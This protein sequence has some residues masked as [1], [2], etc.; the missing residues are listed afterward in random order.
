MSGEVGVSEDMD[1][2]SGDMCID[3]GDRETVGG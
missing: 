2:S 3:Y 1:G